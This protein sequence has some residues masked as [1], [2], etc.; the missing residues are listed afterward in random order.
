MMDIGNWMHA[1]HATGRT[2]L[3]SNSRVYQ[4]AVFNYTQNFAYIWDEL[5]LPVT[6]ASDLAEAPEYSSK[7]AKNSRNPSSR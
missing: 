5:V 1:G 2:V 7:P 4:H 6:Y 3:F